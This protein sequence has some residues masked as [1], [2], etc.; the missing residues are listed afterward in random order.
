MLA[1][2]KK[3]SACA[4]ARRRR[5]GRA[6]C[7]KP[8]ERRGGAVSGLTGEEG[9]ATARDGTTGRRRDAAAHAPGVTGDREVPRRGMGRKLLPFFAFVLGVLAFALASSPAASA[10][11]GEPCLQT[12]TEEIATDSADYAPGSTVHITGTG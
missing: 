11:T 5:R 4:V 10:A 1:W 6:V 9:K 7:G 8:G 12:G 3:L 2:R